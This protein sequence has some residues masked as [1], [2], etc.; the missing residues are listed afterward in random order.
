M[1]QLHTLGCGKLGFLDLARN[2][3]ITHHFTS[4]A[5]QAMEGWAININLVIGTTTFS[6]YIDIK[7]QLLSK[8]D[9][10]SN[11]INLAD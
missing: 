4:T 5:A 10:K 3:H 2:R 7:K 1:R 9:S 8:I 11:Y 6:N